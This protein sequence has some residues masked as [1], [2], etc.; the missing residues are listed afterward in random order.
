MLKKMILWV[1]LVGITV[2]S[3]VLVTAAIQAPPR[4]EGDD[5]SSGGF[6]PRGTAAAADRAAERARPEEPQGVGLEDIQARIRASDEEWKVI[7]PKLRRVMLAYAA[8]EA[9]FDE[10]SIGSTDNPGFA[11]PGRGGRGGPGGGPGGPGKDSFSSP[12]DAGPFGRGGSGPGGFERGG[13]GP[14]G[15]G[16]SGPGPGGFGPGGA[17]P[18]GFG[19]GRGGFGRGG[20]GPGGFGGMPPFGGPPGFG[21]PGG[22]AVTQKLVELRTALADPNTTPEQLQEKIGGVRSARQ[23]AKTELAAARKDLLELLTPD[24]EAILVSL[25]YLD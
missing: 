6:S 18:D 15:F 17:G 25:N 12:G 11:S 14:E 19:R 16:P 24:Q 10:S 2:V 1:S 7:G 22:N 9:S 13:P 21:G 3:V 8:A 5:S 4:G 20:R 23:K